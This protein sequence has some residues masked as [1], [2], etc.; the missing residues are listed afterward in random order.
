IPF[1]EGYPTPHALTVDEIKGLVTAFV[2]ATHR[3]DSAGFDLIEIHAA[4]G[5]LLHSFL[6]PLSNQRTDDYGGSFEN[7]ARFLLEV[8]A[9]VRAVWDKPIS[10][11]I[12][13]TDWH[14]EGWTEADSVALGTL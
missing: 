13:A 4:H 9:A 7:R 6:S 11:R 1:S 3:A 5:Y 14:T 8:V 12:S 2:D 10:V